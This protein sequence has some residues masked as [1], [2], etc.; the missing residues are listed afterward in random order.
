[1]MGLIKQSDLIETASL[2]YRY[3]D[4]YSV[5]FSFFFLEIFISIPG[6]F[7]I[8]TRNVFRNG[9]FLV[10]G[11]LSIGSSNLHR[12]SCLSFVLLVCCFCPLSVLCWYGGSRLKSKSAKNKKSQRHVTSFDVNKHP[13]RSSNKSNALKIF[14]IL[15]K[16]SKKCLSFS[17]TQLKVLLFFKLS[18]G[19]KYF[20]FPPLLKEDSQFDEHIFQMGWFNHQLV[21]DFFEP[22]FFFDWRD[23]FW[24]KIAGT[25]SRC[26]ATLGLT[27]IFLSVTNIRQ[28]ARETNG[29]NTS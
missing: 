8:L 12:L 24:I 20:L 7:P 19:F 2:L 1:M 26:P 23:F 13:E 27:S 28:H 18:G 25:V 17:Q 16:I 15:G 21:T 11:L 29:K 3:I 14:Q 6:K 4:V 9:L 5:S 22:F 10:V